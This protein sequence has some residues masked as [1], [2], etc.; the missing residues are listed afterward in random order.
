MQLPQLYHLRPSNAN[1]FQLIVRRC[2]PL[3]TLHQLRRP[4]LVQTGGG[5]GAVDAEVFGD[6]E[7]GGAG[8]EVDDGD[9]DGGVAG[10]GEVLGGV[11]EGEAGVEEGLRA[12]SRVS[13]WA[14][15]LVA[16]RPMVP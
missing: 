2:Q 8:G 15:V 4:S 11:V 1:V 7:G 14:M 9:G 6:G 16:M 5:G 13:P 3:P 10:P 12:V